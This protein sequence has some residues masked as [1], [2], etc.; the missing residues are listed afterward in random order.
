MLDNICTHLLQ[1]KMAFYNQGEAIRV[2]QR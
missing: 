2:M 1:I